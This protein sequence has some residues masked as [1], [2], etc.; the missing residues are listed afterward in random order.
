MI[1][2]ALLALSVSSVIGQ[3]FGDIDL[4]TKKFVKPGDFFDIGCG[5]DIA[6]AIKVSLNL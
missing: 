5:S 4:C 2:V 3:R 6:V 1:L